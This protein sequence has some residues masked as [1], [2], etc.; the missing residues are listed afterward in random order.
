MTAIRHNVNIKTTPEKR[1]MKRSLPQGRTGRSWK[2]QNKTTCQT[3][4]RIC[5]HIYLRNILRNEM[6]VT[7]LIPKTKKA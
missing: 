1:L 6:N 4:S 5:E 2:G 3:R 7:N